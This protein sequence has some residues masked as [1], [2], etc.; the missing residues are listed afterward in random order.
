MKLLAAALLLSV[1]AGA[2][3]PASDPFD[4][5]TRS[6]KISVGGIKIVGEDHP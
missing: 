6:P 2:Q 3:A 4:D 1:S 5:A